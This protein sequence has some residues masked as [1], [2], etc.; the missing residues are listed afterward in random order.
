[1]DGEE[2]KEE[3]AE[4]LMSDIPRDLVH[5]INEGLRAGAR[6]AHAKAKDL[7]AGHRANGLGQERHFLMNEAFYTALA[8]QNASPTPIHGNDLIIGHLGELMLG[9]LNVGPVWNN[10]RRSTVR[11]RLCSHNATLGEWI[12]ADLFNDPPLHTAL[13]VFFVAIFAKDQAELPASIQVAV[14]DAGMSR[15]IFRE[16]IEKFMHRYD[17]ISLAQQDL[18]VPRLKLALSKQ[19]EGGK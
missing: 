17:G 11:R 3:I 12:E 13:V 19:N 18:A 14:P 16:S 15:W 2:Y 1:M 7:N 5:A 10:C 6:R 4:L 8:A 9:R